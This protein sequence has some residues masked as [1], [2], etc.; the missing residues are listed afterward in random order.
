MHRHAN[1]QYYYLDG[2]KVKLDE[3]LLEFSDGKKSKV[4]PRI[5]EVLTTLVEQYPNIVS[6]EELI[7]KI[8]SNDKKAGENL[9]NNAIWQLRHIFKN[10]EPQVEIIETVRKLGY[11][12]LVAPQFDDSQNNIEP[13]Q[14]TNLLEPHIQ[15]ELSKDNRF[16]PIWFLSV[17]CL[18][19]FAFF[20]FQTNEVS[21]PVI[22][23][24]SLVTKEPGV[25]L[26]PSPSPNGEWLAFVWRK[27]GARPELYIKELKNN[28]TPPRRLTFN[29][30][31]SE[32]TAWDNHSTWAY[33][34]SRTQIQQGCMIFRVNILTGES[35][36]L[37]KCNRKI[38]SRMPFTVS[39]D[40]QFLVYFNRSNILQGEEGIW[41]VDLANL[42]Q[43][44]R[45]I[46]IPCAEL[47]GDFL[48]GVLFSP[49]SKKIAVTAR[50][51]QYS[52][53]LYI[54]DL[55]NYKVEKVVE[56]YINIV[57]FDWHP[58]NQTIVFSKAL[59][60]NRT[61]E[62]VELE[63]KTITPL[64]IDGFSYPKFS[65]DGKQIFYHHKRENYRISSLPL[66]EN[67]SRTLFPILMSN[68]SHR[69]QDYSEKTQKIVYTS[70]ESGNFEL[71]TADLD[72]ENRLQLTSL[73]N[74]VRFPVWS[75]DGSKIAFIGR[76]R[77][78]NES[79]LFVLDL[80]SQKVT[81]LKSPF[82]SHGRPSWSLDDKHLLAISHHQSKSR[83]YEFSFDDTP[84][85]LLTDL[86]IYYAKE[87]KEGLYAVN[88]KGELWLLS[89]SEPD[90]NK[91]LLSVDEFGT[92][93]AWIL[94]DKGIY[95]YKE[96]GGKHQIHFFDKQTQKVSLAA[97]LPWM[98]TN[99]FST[100]SYSSASN[101]LLLTV[102]DIPQIDIKKVVNATELNYKK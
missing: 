54:I 55:E 58:D 92:R 66:N 29:G 100:M 19:V 50:A 26:F 46:E 37:V 33:Y 12:L 25:E 99:Q 16:N 18:F 10:K 36:Q 69:S 32:I 72:G 9:L 43:I 79:K 83:Y 88:N 71:W 20:I 53:N 73:K 94:T 51:D 74:E 47:C 13:S 42:D 1:C 35:E 91:K 6:R 78:N 96:V 39:H 67:I 27:R 70:N 45:E 2:C 57:G 38:S 4:Q 65:R 101:Q 17:F 21:K 5:L 8:W 3:S 86:I 82:E 95:F 56:D 85:K 81:M 98:V 77:K 22:P 48:T 34:A 14:S 62:I 80:N 97:Y 7:S 59:P 24:L 64:D 68:F 60:D 87:S 102:N 11:R 75:H 40:G 90:K 31:I 63:N 23:E 49:D 93:Y 76:V 44:N 15:T 89:K 61:G 41:L 84:P 52:E 28:N 30:I